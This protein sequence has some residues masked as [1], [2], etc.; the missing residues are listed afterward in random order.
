[1]A[2]LTIDPLQAIRTAWEYDPNEPTYNADASRGSEK[3]KFAARAKITIEPRANKDCWVSVAAQRKADKLTI[4]D[5]TPS[6]R[7]V[8]R[9]KKRALASEK[10][11]FAF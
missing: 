10:L 8:N 7:T 11:T 4:S 3:F 1:M 6:F 9:L 2:R 5:G